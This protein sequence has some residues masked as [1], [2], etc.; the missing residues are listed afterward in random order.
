[1]VE[2]LQQDD[3]NQQS[4]E[5]VD[6]SQLSPAFHRHCYLHR[7]HVTFSNPRI[8]TSECC[9]LVLV[10]KGPLK[11]FCLLFCGEL[12]FDI[13]S[14]SNEHHERWGGRKLLQEM[15]NSSLEEM[16]SEGSNNCT[17]PGK[18]ETERGHPSIREER[19]NT[20]LLGPPIFSFSPNMG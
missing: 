18:T 17:V 2:K 11:L 8:Y 9:I 16:E 4:Q 15:D 3:N 7:H 5:N 20:T 10:L 14:R 13:S 12:G 19:A 6:I 1:M